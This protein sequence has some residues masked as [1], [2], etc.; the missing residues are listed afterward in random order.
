M[1]GIPHIVFTVN[2]MD[3]VDFD[4]ERFRSIERDLA[5]LS[6]RLGLGDTRRSRSR[7]SPATTSSKPSTRMPWWTGGTFLERLE[8]IEIAGDRDVRT[9]GSPCSG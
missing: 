7:R 2:K 5:D 8:T 6:D 4:E 3:L 1:L 9:L